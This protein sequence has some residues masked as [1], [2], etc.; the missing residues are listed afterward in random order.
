MEELIKIR[1]ETQFESLIQ[2]L[3]DQQYGVCDAFFD[4]YILTGLRDNL[5]RDK[6][7]GKMH[8]AGVGNK[9]DFQKN[10]IVRGD[11]I[12]W[13]EKDST[14]PFEAFFMRKVTDFVDYLNRTCYT[15]IND[16]EFH[17][18]NYEPFSFYKRHLDQFKSD[19]GRK[20]SLVLYLN[21]NW[22]EQD[23]GNIS[24]YL[25]GN[26]VDNIYPTNG[27]IVFF[28]SDEMEH[29]VHPSFNRSRISIAG[30]LKSV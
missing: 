12:R 24:L 13:I 26:K 15:S 10:A 18:A 20:Y 28:K 25:G 2:G 4:E 8:P 23:G 21:E 27:R 30:W 19:K 9:F 5:L 11:L 7:A 17:Y 22:Q 29:E 16:Y 14:D 3:I 1:E 6:A